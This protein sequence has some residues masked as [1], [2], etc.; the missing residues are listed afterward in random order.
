MPFAAA[1]P[2]RS[3]HLCAPLPF[4]AVLAL[5]HP[6]AARSPSLE[7]LG[8][9]CQA[10]AEQG[11]FDPVLVQQFAA[12]LPVPPA[13]Q[14]CSWLTTNQTDTEACDL[15]SL[16]DWGLTNGGNFTPPDCYNPAIGPAE[17]C[18]HGS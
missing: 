10:I 3:A 1:R 13:R 14:F 17:E 16:L 18:V 7:S 9:F 11:G 8:P 4:R 15:L 2:R 5:L 12:T 6:A